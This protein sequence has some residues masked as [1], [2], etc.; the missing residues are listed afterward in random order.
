MLASNA[1]TLVEQLEPDLALAGVELMQ[2][3]EMEGEHYW[4]AFVESAERSLLTLEQG[5]S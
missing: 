5:R 4:Q 1:R 2:A 3:R